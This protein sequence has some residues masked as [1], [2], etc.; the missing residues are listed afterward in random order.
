MSE[1][2]VTELAALPHLR[3]R[4]RRFLAE[5]QAR[6]PYRPAIDAW[7]TSASA[8]FSRALG[9]QGWIG[10]TWPKEYGG[11]ECSAFERLA[12]VE[13]LLTAGA[14]VAAHW[15]AERQIGPGILKNGTER[16]KRAFIPEIVAGRLFFAVGMSEPGSGS[17]LASVRTRAERVPGGWRIN[18]AKVWSSGAHRAHYMLTLCR[19]AVSE[20]RHAGLSQFLV[21]LDAPGVQVRPIRSLDGEAEFCEVVFDDVLVDDDAL[22]GAEG[23]GWKQ[24]TG[25]LAL[26]RNGAERYVSLYLETMMA[27]R[28]ARPT[29]RDHAYL[30]ETAAAMWSV[31][32]LSLRT[33]AE[34]NR[35][36][37]RRE[38]DAALVKDVGTVFEQRQVERARRLL[39]GRV[40]GE[41]DRA[42]LRSAVEHAPSITLRGGTTEVLRTIIWSGLDTG[43]GRA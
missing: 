34:E 11:G 41:E 13:E 16:Q 33:L 25:E 22:L 30:G 28:L 37:A 36:Q 15:F 39:A 10:M 42:L 12:V 32:A 26:E 40:P 9:S 24:V 6:A 21:P 19:S 7:L 29:R 1:R 14:P 5:E 20:D 31:R 38:L 4:V 35:P 43:G 2:P 8:E 3:A 23:D 18:G 27:A 17:D